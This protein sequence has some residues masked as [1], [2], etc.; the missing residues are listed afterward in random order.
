VNSLQAALLGFIQGVTEFLPI[1]SSG[2]LVLLQRLL[3]LDVAEGIAFDVLLHVATLIAVVAVF[4]RD[5]LRLFSDRR[6]ELGLLILGTIPAAIVGLLFKDM[7][8]KMAENTVA[9]GLSLVFTGA[10]LLLTGWYMK[11]CS[12]EKN[13][14]WRSALLIGLAQAAAIMPGISRSGMTI[15]VAI[16]C[17]VVLSG[18]V[19]FSFLLAIPVILGGAVLELRH[20]D[21]MVD[22]S[23]WLPMF[24]GFVA[25]V[26]FGLLALKIVAASVEK[27]K[28]PYFG[29]YCAPLGI[30]V[31]ILTLGGGSA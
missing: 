21:T 11:N 25:A 20:L 19:R 29:Y 5:I 26:V 13:V 2:H 27:R 17:G 4:W 9:V 16:M 31:V 22:K 18:A 30:I 23:G 24:V 7:F 3:G 15:A 8:E 12:S 10:V 14:D 28:F 1:S 6:G